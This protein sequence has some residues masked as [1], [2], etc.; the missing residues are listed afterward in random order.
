MGRT[1]LRVGPCIGGV[2]LGIFLLLLPGST[3]LQ[4]FSPSPSQTSVFITL[5]WTRA[6]PGFASRES[7]VPSGWKRWPCWF[8]SVSDYRGTSC[9][10]TDICPAWDRYRSSGCH[11]RSSSWPIECRLTE[12]VRHNPRSVRTWRADSAIWAEVLGSSTAP[13]YCSASNLR[14]GVTKWFPKWPVIVK[15]WWLNFRFGK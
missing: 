6:S 1:L 15:N 5:P 12:R 3:T 13:K 4:E 9:K 7:S 2:V 14:T 8:R 10:P 11:N